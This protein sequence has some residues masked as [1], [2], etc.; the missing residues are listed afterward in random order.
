MEAGG[1][2]AAVDSGEPRPR[3]ESRSM[4]PGLRHGV[5]LPVWHGE[6]AVASARDRDRIAGGFGSLRLPAVSPAGTEFRG[7]IAGAR[8]QR[9]GLGRDTGGDG[10]LRGYQPRICTDERGSGESQT[11]ELMKVRSSG[12]E[13]SIRSAFAL[14]LFSHLQQFHDS[15]PVSSGPGAFQRP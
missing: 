10:T 4:A 5:H 7:G 8:R 6:V 9:G 15:V 3:R 13:E 2:A 14:K 11:G 1:K 12:D